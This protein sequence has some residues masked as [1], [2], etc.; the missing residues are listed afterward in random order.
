MNNETQKQILLETMINNQKKSIAIAY[1]L[2]VLF[3]ILGIHRMYL[4]R[5]L[6]GLLML[7]LTI[8]TFIFPFVSSTFDPTISSTFMGLLIFWVILDIILIPIIAKH[9]Q[10]KLREKLKREID[11]N[12]SLNT[13]DQVQSS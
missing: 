4:G 10:K 11:A 7:G 12:P 6:S 13:L 3:N 2:L 1:I 9:H 5:W 8:F